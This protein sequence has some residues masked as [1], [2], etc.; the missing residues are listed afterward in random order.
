MEI[1]EQVKTFDGFV[2]MTKF[3]VALGI[4]IMVTLLIVYKI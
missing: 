1:Q 2:K 3:S 4:A